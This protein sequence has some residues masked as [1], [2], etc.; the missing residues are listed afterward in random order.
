MA[1]ILFQILII[2]SSRIVGSAASISLPGCPDRCGET[3]IPYPFGMGTNCSLSDDFNVTCDANNTEY[4][5]FFHK[6]T[7]GKPTPYLYGGAFE[8]VYISVPLGQ[9]RF[10]FPIS[11]Q[12]YNASMK[13]DYSTEWGILLSDGIPFWINNEKNKLIVTG[14]NTLGYLTI[15][16]STGFSIGCLSTCDSVDSLNKYGPSCSGIGCCQT[17]IPKVTQSFFVDF[18]ERF[19]HSLVHDFSPCSYAMVVESA[20]FVFNTTSIITD[21]IVDKTST[22]VYDWFVGNTTCEIA[23]RNKSSNACKSSNSFCLNS[24]TG[25]GYI[26]NCSR[27]YEGNPYLQGPGGC[28]G[29][30][31]ISLIFSLF[32]FN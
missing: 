2:L 16:N 3:L 21:E 25:H 12:C 8:I 10:N 17:D 5:D 19:N 1:T 18:D 30:H 27:G 15:D 20:G 22:A 11:Y 9:A 31:V 4:L 28:Q 23:Q 26:C 6:R 13:K 29:I 14:C 24:S 32:K 7:T